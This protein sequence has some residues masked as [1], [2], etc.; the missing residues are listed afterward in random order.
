MSCYVKKIK[1]SNAASEIYVIEIKRQYIRSRKC[2][3]RH[4]KNNTIVTLIFKRHII[5]S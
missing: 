2:D 4:K 1:L 5:D 3:C